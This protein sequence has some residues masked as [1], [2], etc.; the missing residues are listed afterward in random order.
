MTVVKGE[1]ED[2]DSE[3]AVSYQVELEIVDPKLVKDD[4][5]FYKLVHKVY[6]V[7]KLI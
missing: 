3:D 5:D 1:P 4:N 7:M 6:D 2:P